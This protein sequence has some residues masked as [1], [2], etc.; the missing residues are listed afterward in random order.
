MYFQVKKS[1]NNAFL[2]DSRPHRTGLLLKARTFYSQLIFN[3]MLKHILIL[4]LCLKTLQY[5]KFSAIGFVS[6]RTVQMLLT[7]RVHDG[8]PAISAENF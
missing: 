4:D 6:S 7:F 8:G 5:A 2:P 3:L 1:P